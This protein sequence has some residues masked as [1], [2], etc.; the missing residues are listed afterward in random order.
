MPKRALED[1]TLGEQ[2]EFSRTFTEADVV[3]FVGMTW[4]V[5]PYHTDDEFCKTHRVG[6]RIVPGLLVGSMLTHIG[7]LAAVLASHLAFEFVAPVFIGDT[8]TATC[9]VVEADTTRGWTRIEMTCV[10]Q[11]GE[12]IARGEARGYP[13]RWRDRVRGK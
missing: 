7:G 5:N 11:E 8:I 13:M 12:L 1:F 3:Q 9:A 6:K 4:D 2:A 10:N